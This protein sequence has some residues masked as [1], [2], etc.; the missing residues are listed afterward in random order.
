M[1]NREKLYKR[2]GHVLHVSAEDQAV[3]LEPETGYYYSLNATGSFIWQCLGQSQAAI[4]I[5]SKLMSEFEVDFAA[6]ELDV[7]E[8]LKEMSANSLIESGE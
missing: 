2:R 6:A 4:D 8:F 5:V 1:D 3:L 7:S